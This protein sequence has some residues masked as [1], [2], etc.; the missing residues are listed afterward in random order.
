MTKRPICEC[1]ISIIRATR[2]HIIRSLR[3]LPLNLPPLP[4][5]AVNAGLSRPDVAVITSTSRTAG[6]GGKIASTKE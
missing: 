5:T 3:R 1:R 4:V 6:R 2:A